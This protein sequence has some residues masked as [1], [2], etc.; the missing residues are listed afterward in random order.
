MGGR[1]A[2]V[3]DVT[4]MGA[5]ARTD[6]FNAR[7]QAVTGLFPS[8][9]ILRGNRG[10]EAR[11]AR[12]RVVFGIADKQR[13]AAADVPKEAGLVRSVERPGESWICL[14]LSRHCV[15]WGVSR[16]RHSGSGA[17]P[18]RVFLHRDLLLTLVGLSD[19]SVGNGD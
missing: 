14:P 17:G 4:E 15:C 5:A 2:I 12:A 13:F 11:P 7:R 10:P 6:Y 16:S 19:D 1:G 8:T 3:E 18:N 9:K